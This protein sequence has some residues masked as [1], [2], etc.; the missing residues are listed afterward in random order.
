MRQ[1]NCPRENWL[2]NLMG[3]LY[4]LEEK[5]DEKEAITQY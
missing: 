3:K 2:K 4:S 1:V 5:N